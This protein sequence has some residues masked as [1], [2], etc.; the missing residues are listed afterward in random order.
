MGSAGKGKTPF[1]RRPE[2]EPGERLGITNYI[3]REVVGQG[4]W[5][6]VY[7]A[8]HPE[9]KA[10]VAVKVLSRELAQDKTAVERFRT[11]ARAASNLATK[12]RHIVR[13]TDF[14]WLPD[15]GPPYLIMDWLEGQTLAQ[16]L[17]TEGRLS[18]G[19]AA[20]LFRQIAK[21]LSA[22]HPGIVHRD[23][24][25]D[26]VF[27]VRD[28]ENEELVKILDF[29]I[30]RLQASEVQRT[31]TN[32][33]LGT[34][35]YMSP[36]QC[37]EVEFGPV[38]YRADIYSVGVMLYEALTGQRPFTTEENAWSLLHMHAK[39]PPQP[40]REL[41]SEIPEHLERLILKML[42]KHKEERPQSMD[43]VF[44]A[45]G[46]RPSG[47]IKA[48]PDPPPDPVP[49]LGVTPRPPEVGPIPQ[50]PQP[51]PEPRPPLSASRVSRSRLVLLSS[52]VLVAGAIGIVTYAYTSTAP[53][54]RKTPVGSGPEVKKVAPPVDP[55]RRPPPSPSLP[56]GMVLMSSGDFTFQAGRALRTEVAVSRFA[57]DEAEVTQAAWLAFTG[58]TGGDKALPIY[59]VKP[60]RADEYC[61]SLTPPRRLPTEVEWEYAARGDEHRLTY[62]FANTFDKRCVVWRAP[63]PEPVRSREC[64]KTSS[65]LFH[66]AGNVAEWTTRGDG[67]GFVIRGGSFLTRTE[68]EL[69]AAA[70]RAYKGGPV[71]DVGFR[72]ALALP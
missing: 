60:Q 47:I 46:G 36:E 18:A 69:M 43:E 53:T 34:P 39:Q 26:N 1:P 71:R 51:T 29:G 67:D 25:P 40:P 31:G 56:P 55:E 38:D 8:E 50:P 66:M 32:A 35:Y 11:E 54:P 64:G 27:V 14:D 68:E 15:D 22:A 2:L 63:D 42:G 58:S 45:L 5:G 70:R 24:K 52:G 44:R 41:V 9:I 57:I 13:V 3:I 72:C 21:G 37:S 65:G 20:H 17:K 16:I 28:E 48:P 49:D 10:S 19:R 61:R 6:T 4:G 23:M 30:A 12:S 62:P 7:R 33:L 59:G